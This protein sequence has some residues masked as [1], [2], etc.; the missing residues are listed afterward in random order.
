MGELR[1]LWTHAST[2]LEGNSLTLGD[3]AFVLVD[4]LTVAGKPLKG[5]YEVV[6]HAHAAELL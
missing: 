4:G 1:D 5:H 3:A 2:A 6:G